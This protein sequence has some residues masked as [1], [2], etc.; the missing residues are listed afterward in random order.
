MCFSGLLDDTYNLLVQF[1]EDKDG[2]S[3]LYI[4][5][6]KTVLCKQNHVWLLYLVENC[7]LYL[8][9]SILL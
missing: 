3:V 7:G 2:V 4:L 8:V 1:L 6:F 9:S 5:L